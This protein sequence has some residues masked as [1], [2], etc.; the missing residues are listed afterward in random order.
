MII[1]NKKSRVEA[2]MKATREYIVGVDTPDEVRAITPYRLMVG[3]ADE[4]MILGVP[5][6]LA[7]RAAARITVSLPDNFHDDHEDAFVELIRLWSKSMHVT[8]MTLSDDFDPK[9]VPD[10]F[11]SLVGQIVIEFS[12]E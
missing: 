6:P 8:Y 7:C 9:I 2:F 11:L 5:S 4:L 3:I 12:F 10:M 1:G